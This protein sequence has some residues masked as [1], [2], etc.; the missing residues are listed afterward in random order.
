LAVKH[1]SAHRWPRVIKFNPHHLVLWLFLGLSQ[2]VYV[3]DDM[4]KGL[5][6]M[7]LGVIN[8]GMS[9]SVWEY[10]SGLIDWCLTTT[11]AV[12]QLY[13]GMSK[14]KVGDDPHLK[15]KTLVIMCDKIIYIKLRELIWH[16]NYYTINLYLKIIH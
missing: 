9:L 1:Q 11:L 3:R 7:S 15:T 2:W 13:C 16:M 4:S 10:K 14:T 6:I 12:F 8:H 5:K